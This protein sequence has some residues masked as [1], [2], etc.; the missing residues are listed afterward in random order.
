[1]YFN[2]YV[3]QYIIYILCILL[4][5]IEFHLYE[6]LYM[7]QLILNPRR[8][9]NTLWM[10]LSLIFYVYFMKIRHLKCINNFNII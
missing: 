1:M 10:N 3:L 2:F 4:I 6:L 5:R 9:F 8:Y 7:K